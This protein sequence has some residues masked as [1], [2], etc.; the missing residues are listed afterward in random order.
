MQL[1]DPILAFHA[2]LQQ[3]RRDIHAHPELCFEEHR[4]SGVVAA[5]LQ[6]WGIPIVRGLAGTGIVGVI[7]HGTSS[8]AIGLRADMD[9]L[10]MQEINSFAHTSQHEGKMHACGHDGHTAMLLGAAHYLSQ[11]KNFDGTVY[12]IFQPAEEGGGGAKRMIDEGLFDLC[13][14]DAVYGMHNWPGAAVGSFGVRVGPMMA[15]SNEFE[16]VVSGKGSHAAQPHKSVDPIMVAVQI[17]QSW[18]TIISRNTSPLESAV[19]SI[20]QIHSG[21]ATNVI[22]DQATLIGTVRGFTDEI[23]DLLEQRMQAVAVHTAAA[24]DAKVEFNF[25][26][27]YPPLLNHA[28]QTAFAA[29]VMQSIVGIEHVDVQVEP[30]MGAE[31][32]AFML[33]AK[34]GCYVFIG[35]GEGEHR[36]FGHGLGPCNLHNPS[37]DFNDDLLP[38]G[39]TYWVRLAEAYLTP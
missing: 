31:D 26:R 9:A 21:S 7:K 1:I 18:Q 4:T 30:T 19:L 29:Q 3:I 10:P 28:D 13:P 35:N 33:Q 34:P 39:A 15:S 38:I 27:N 2:E 36:D 32:F 37:Y 12:L 23:I 25:K 17:A 14:M 6:E 8:K 22:P 5:K 11:H 20:T 16:V 24:F